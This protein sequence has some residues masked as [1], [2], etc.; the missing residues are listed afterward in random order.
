MNE[1]EKRIALH[2][3]AAIVRDAI[4]GKDRPSADA[5]TKLAEDAAQAIL[6]G[7]KKLNEST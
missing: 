6:A 2:T 1:E 3:V 4:D 7:S 5:L